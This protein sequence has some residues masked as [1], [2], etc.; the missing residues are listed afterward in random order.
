MGFGFKK[1]VKNSIKVS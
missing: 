1:N